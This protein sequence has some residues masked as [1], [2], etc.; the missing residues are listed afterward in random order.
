MAIYKSFWDVII[1]G[2][3]TSIGDESNPGSRPLEGSYGKRNKHDKYVDVN[4]ALHGCAL[5][6]CGR[7]SP[8]ASVAI[9]Q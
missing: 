5:N 2:A 3:L 6:A 1:K 9:D 4:G 7:M 8:E